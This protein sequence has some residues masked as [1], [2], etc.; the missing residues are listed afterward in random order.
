M[1]RKQ[2]IYPVLC[3]LI[4]CLTAATP[5]VMAESTMTI[6]EATYGAV[7]KP[8][9]VNTCPTVAKG[10]ATQVVANQC[11]GRTTCDY[12][13]DVNK[14]PGGDPAQGCWKNFEVSY[15]CSGD[16]TTRTMAVGGESGEA[17]DQHLFLNCSG[18][19]GIQVTEATYGG[20]T[21]P[22]HVHN[23]NTVPTGNWTGHVQHACNGLYDCTYVPQVEHYPADD[24]APGCFKSFAVTYTC[25]GETTTR[26]QTYPVSSTGGATGHNIPLACPRPQTSNDYQITAIPSG[27]TNTLKGITRNGTGRYVAVG[28]NGVILYSDDG[29]SW[30]KKTITGQPSFHD[31]VYGGGLYIAVGGAASPTGNAYYSTNGSIWTGAYETPSGTTWQ[32]VA[33]PVNSTA[34]YFIAVGSSYNS[35][36]AQYSGQ[37]MERGTNTLNQWITK[38]TI[39]NTFFTSAAFYNETRVAVGRDI[40]FAV[41]GESN[42][43]WQ[44]VTTNPTS[45]IL[46]SVVWGGDKFIAVGD[47]GTLVTSPGGKTW[48]SRTSGT[49][50]HLAGVACSNDN[51]NWCVAVGPSVLLTSTD[52]ITWTSH[53]SLAG[54]YGF[55]AIT[56]TSNGFTAVG[57][58]GGLWHIN[59]Q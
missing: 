27:I 25:P 57:K 51:D 31:V 10:N 59:K 42:G 47:Q 53:P 56:W 50:I 52:G 17:N 40:Y 3:S 20:H 43:N 26:S 28:A 12:G 30:T 1:R 21:Y 9:N 36:T 4:I 54:S 16:T 46:R 14:F 49:G 6:S 33:Y 7:T 11:N 55:E 41:T 5:P 2:L 8:I 48:T 39:A 13:V 38:T 23:C 35:D 15:A 45:N 22:V 18:D 37:S 24:P 32:G 19:S 44:K 58:N 29:T 34:N